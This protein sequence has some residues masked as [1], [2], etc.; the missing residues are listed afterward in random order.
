MV[1]PA[2]VCAGYVR[3]KRP[4]QF[5]PTP[6]CPAAPN[7]VR[8]GVEVRAWV[9]TAVVPESFYRWLTPLFHQRAFR[10]VKDFIVWAGK[11]PI[12]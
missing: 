6:T 10:P 11:I 12:R 9:E 5:V 2:W 8:V 7:V 1:V 3:A 4:G